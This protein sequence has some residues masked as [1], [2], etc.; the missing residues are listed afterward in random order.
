MSDPPAA[1][2]T[3]TQTPSDRSTEFKA[4]DSGERFNGNTLVVEAYAALWLVVMGWVFL[5]WRKQAGLAERLDDLE[6]VM[7]RA[8]AIR[9]RAEKKAR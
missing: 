3:S 4:V 5:L 2:P 7:D 9:D 1:A 8:A 6:R